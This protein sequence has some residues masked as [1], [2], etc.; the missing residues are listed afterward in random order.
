MIRIIVVVMEYVDCPD[1]DAF[2]VFMGETDEFLPVWLDERRKEHVERFHLWP[3][4]KVVHC[5]WQRK[6]NVLP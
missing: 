6:T 3:G 2:V 4:E 1:E 5:I